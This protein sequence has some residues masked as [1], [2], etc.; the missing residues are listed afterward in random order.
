M[1]QAKSKTETKVIE[2]V[3]VLEKE[4]KNM[5]R[6][7]LGPEPL[8]MGSVY[9]AKTAVGTGVHNLKLKIVAGQGDER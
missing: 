9:I 5:Y 4:T 3:G 7:Q 1:S 2:A 8:V 6:Y